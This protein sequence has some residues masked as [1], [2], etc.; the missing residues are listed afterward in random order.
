VTLSLFIIIIIVFDV[1]EKLD[2][3]LKKEAPVSEILLNYYLNYVP[4]FLNLFSPV[5]IFISVIFS[6]TI[7]IGLLSAL[8]AI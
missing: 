4:F 8:W 6:L 7:I 3:F 2:D 1:S 5:F